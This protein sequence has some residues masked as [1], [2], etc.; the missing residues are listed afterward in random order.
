FRYLFASAERCH[1]APPCRSDGGRKENRANC[2]KRR[3]DSFR[4]RRGSSAE[5]DAEASRSR[6]LSGFDGQRR[7][8]S[9]PNLSPTQTRNRFS[10]SGFGA[11]E[12]K[13]LGSL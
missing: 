9:G 1:H 12:A 5:S 7:R 11:A 2:C 10:G 8:R 13:W 4:R 6:R 3:N